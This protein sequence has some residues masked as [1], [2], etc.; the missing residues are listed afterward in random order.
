M[1]TGGVL[2]VAG[3]ELH[4][5]RILGS[6]FRVLGH[7]DSGVCFRVSVSGGWVPNLGVWVSTFEFQF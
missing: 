3:C 6:V 2:R 4:V 7:R 5:C 1:L